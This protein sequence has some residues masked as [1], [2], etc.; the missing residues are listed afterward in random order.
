MVS[1]FSQ[2][3]G[4]R[5]LIAAIVLVAAIGG[6]RSHA[7]ASG[8]VSVYAGT[9]DTCVVTT[10]GGA[11]CWGAN[12][13]GQLGNGTTT[14]NPTPS[15]VTGL[16]S[17][18]L[19]VAERAGTP[20]GHTCALTAVGAVECWGSN[21]VGQLGDGTAAD[22]LSP[23]NTVGL[24]TIASIS[25][26]G[27]H[28]CAVA[29]G[30]GGVKCW[31]WNPYGQLG[32]GTSAGPQ[33]CNAGGTPYSCSTTPVDVMGL[34]SGAAAVAAGVFHTC[35]L[36]VSGGV[37]CWGNDDHGQL[38]DGT[39]TNSSVPV[40]VAGLAAGAA[41]IS[42]GLEHSCVV[43]T[44]SGVKC[45]GTGAAGELGNGGTGC[46][47]VGWC[48][49]P[50]DVAGLATGVA[51]VSA[52][53]V[54]TCALT[55]A[56]GVKCWGRNDNG[57]LGIGSNTGLASCGGYPCSLTPV[58]VPGLTS[59]VADVSAGL[60]H[61]CAVLT[62]GVVKCWG[63]GTYGQMGDGSTAPQ[64]SPGYTSLDA[65]D[66]GYSDV[67][68]ALLGKDFT[69]YCAIMRADVDGDGQITILDLSLVAAHFLQ[70]VPPAP[71][72]LDQGPPPFD[73]QINVLDLSKM[74]AQFGKSVTACP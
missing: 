21:D 15:A 65:D 66:D 57:Q 29:A 44:S 12:A 52:G 46:G 27:E 40:D 35:A 39:T 63:S 37:K 53:G 41:S 45:W 20:Y 25:V 34:T 13:G 32:D 60:D 8:A 28:A 10:E 56:G 61:T 3:V 55:F 68:E 67:K 17:G 47:G 62:S 36:T 43:T 42:A 4:R 54:H 18:V 72:R 31:G 30:T 5:L 73:D 50:V 14:D 1:R 23:T 74:A 48:T 22:R 26:G 2:S 11:M 59:G 58:D 16:T 51:A 6:P 24:P 71:Q 9:Y 64:S 70:A 19:D 49:A 33:T 38:G 7:R 69:L